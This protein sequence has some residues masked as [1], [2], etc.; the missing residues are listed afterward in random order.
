ML[1]IYIITE[2]IHYL[3]TT[4]NIL[5]VIIIIH[6]TI[7]LLWDTVVASYNLNLFIFKGPLIYLLS[8]LYLHHIH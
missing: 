2:N 3:V 1:I 4:T 5:L 8:F 6:I 7:F